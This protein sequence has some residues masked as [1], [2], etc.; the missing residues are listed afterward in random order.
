MQNRKQRAQVLA[1]VGMQIG[2][3]G[4]VSFL[5]QAAVDG[6][7][8]QVPDGKEIAVAAQVLAMAAGR[9][10][11][12]ALYCSDRSVFNSGLEAF[13]EGIA[14]T[15]VQARDYLEKESRE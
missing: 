2:D 15:A 7:R 14:L 3:E 5:I 6:M 13:C 9:A 12:A 11:A 4:L 8:G 1:D 10:A